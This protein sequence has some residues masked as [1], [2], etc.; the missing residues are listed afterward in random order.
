MIIYLSS[1]RLESG[2]F[3]TEMLFMLPLL[4]ST[5]LIWK[6]KQSNKRNFILFPLLGLISSLA[7]LF[8]PVAILPISGIFLWLSFHKKI[9][10]VLMIPLFII[11]FLFPILLIFIYFNHYHAVPSLI[12]NLVNYNRE[13]NKAGLL[14]LNEPI[15]N[16]LNWLKTVPGVLEPFL[17]LS[18]VTLYW[19]RKSKSYLWWVGLIYIITSWIGAKLGG[20]REFPHYYL[21]MVLG[22]TFCSLL[23]FEKL[24]NQKK[25]TVAILITLFL[26]SWVVFPEF[27]I[28][29]SGPSA[30]LRGEFGS[31][32]YWFNDAPKVSNWILNN[33]N[34]N[35]SF[36]V[37]AN[38][39]EIYFYSQRKSMTEHINFYSFFYRPPSVKENWLKAVKNSP[40]DWIITYWLPVNDPP[41]YKELTQ[42]FPN[43][44]GYNRVAEV[45]TYTIFQKG[46]KFFP[47]EIK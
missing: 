24:I 41:S 26:A 16:I 17:I 40:P 42:L 27:Q 12:E 28:L 8:K 32:G 39:P 30:I 34:K 18:L 33:T 46:N 43:M 23:L 35:D 20:T 2:S 6:L 21:P 7:V 36:L 14:I 4:L 15:L 5:F 11:G 13:Y 25:R 45:G 9:N 1:I 31:A 19:Y 10:I 44:T 47:T 29:R 37:W 38:E 3:N 22:L